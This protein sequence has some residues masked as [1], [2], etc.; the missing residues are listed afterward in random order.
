MTADFEDVVDEIGEPM[1][2]PGDRR[3]SPTPVPSDQAVPGQAI[4]YLLRPNRLQTLVPSLR[5]TL[6][7]IAG[8]ALGLAGQ[9]ALT[10]PDCVMAPP[11][12]RAEK[13]IDR[14]AGGREHVHRSGV[15]DHREPGLRPKGTEP[16]NGKLPGGINARFRSKHLVYG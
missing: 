8:T 14:Y 5:R 15:V 6:A 7:K 13:G 3:T 11:V 1:C 12:G 10:L 9:D 2:Q 4:H 16:G